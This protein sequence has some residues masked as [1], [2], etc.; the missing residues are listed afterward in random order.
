MIAENG[1]AIFASNN[2]V[3]DISQSEFMN[4]I[5]SKDGIITIT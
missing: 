3:L 1:A 5:V 2:A 4:N